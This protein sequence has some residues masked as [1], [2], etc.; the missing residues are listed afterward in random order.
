MILYMHTDRQ[1]EKQTDGPTDGRHDD[2]NSLSYCVA[3]RSAK[4][5]HENARGNINCIRRTLVNKYNDCWVCIRT[6]R[7]TSTVC[8]FD[9][10]TGI[11]IFQHD[12][13]RGH[14]VVC[15]LVLIILRVTFRLLLVCSMCSV[16]D[17]DY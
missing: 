6:Q 16:L 4:K 15:Q 8:S 11:S 12:D 3:A 9:H 14:S 13:T 5:T 1:T 2:A 10:T 17:L 7:R